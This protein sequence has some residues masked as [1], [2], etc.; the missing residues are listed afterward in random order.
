MGWEETAICI[1]DSDGRVVRELAAL[2]EPEALV[3]ALR[4][5]AVA[6]ARVGL[7]ACPLAPWLFE[8]LAGAGLPVCACG[9]DPRGGSQ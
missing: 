7:E 9:D 2:S 4:A 8:H 6:Y 3:G 5:A 1:I